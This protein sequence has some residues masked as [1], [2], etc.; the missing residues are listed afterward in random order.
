MYDK[1]KLR[2][3]LT[4]EL[5]RTVG[6]DG[7][8]FPPSHDVYN[9]IS[10][11]LK[12]S[13]SHITPKHIYTILKGDRN[14]MYNAV[15]KAFDIDKKAFYK[16]DSKDSNFNASIDL[17]NISTSE[18]VKNFKLLISEEKWLQIKPTC[19]TYGRDK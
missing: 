6:D 18:S 13:G 4:N 17:S 16:D 15:L 8:I 3:I 12:N 11:T 7:K 14:G 5:Y 10:E 1:E 19:K 9:S 2:D